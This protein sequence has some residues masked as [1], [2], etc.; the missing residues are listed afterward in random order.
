ML[1]PSGGCPLPKSVHR[2]Q[3]CTAAFYKQSNHFLVAGESGLM[4]GSGMGMKSDRVESVRVFTRVEQQ[5]HDVGV[6]ELRCQR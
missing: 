1:G 3:A 5:P 2:I 4:Q 6:A